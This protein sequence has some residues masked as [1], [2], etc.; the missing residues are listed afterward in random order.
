MSKHKKH[1]G[2][3]L[4]QEAAKILEIDESRLRHYKATS[5]NIEI[6]RR[7][8]NLKYTHYEVASLKQLKRDKRDK[9]AARRIGELCPLVPPKKSGS[10]AHKKE[11][12]ES[13]AP[14]FP[15]SQRLSEFRKLAEKARGATRFFTAP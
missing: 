14:A 6:V 8:H 9:L 12:P 13:R 5:E 1:Y 10:M 2:D 4:Y 7:T 3:G 15:E 11:V